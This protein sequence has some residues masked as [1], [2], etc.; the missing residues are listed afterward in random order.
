M[1]GIESG[2]SANDRLTVDPVSKAA[3]STLYDLSGNIAILPEHSAPAVPSG[4]VAMGMNDR[5][6]IG[7]RLDRLGGQASALHTVLLSDSFEG[8]TV[9]PLRWLITATTMA[10]AATT[11][12]GLVFNSGSITT[13]NTG[14]MLQSTQRFAKTQRTPLQAKF[15]A[16]LNHVNNSVMELGYGDAATFNG[17][18]TAG[19]YWQMTSSGVLQPVVTYNSVDQTGADIRSLINT[20]NYY[21]FDV[22]MD[23]DEATFVCQDTF[24]GLIISRQSIKLPLTGQR[25]LSSTAIPVL[26]R[27]YNTG[28]APATAPQMI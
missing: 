15:R 12:G 16:R 1:A 22:I 8:T 13:I 2:V 6:A 21:T 23:D 25:L 17:A 3:R 19:A 27:Q 28:T 9:H 24:T 7:M 11:V 4:L 14:Y 26:A 5:S 20:A 18:N 10:G